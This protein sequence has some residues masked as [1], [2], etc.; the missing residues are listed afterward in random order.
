MR[1]LLLCKLTS[2]LISLRTLRSRECIA[3]AE[4]ER[5]GKEEALLSQAVPIHSITLW[6]TPTE[7]KTLKSWTLLK[8]FPLQQN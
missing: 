7:D 5:L 6:R 3:A 4:M 2:R 8:E 1:K